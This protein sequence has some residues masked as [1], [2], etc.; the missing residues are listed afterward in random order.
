MSEEADV[1]DTGSLT[2]ESAVGNQPSLGS[3]ACISVASNDNAATGD[4]ISDL[5]PN[6]AASVPSNDEERL[7]SATSA[8]SSAVVPTSAPIPTPTVNSPYTAEAAQ[9]VEQEVERRAVGL[10]EPTANEQAINRDATIALGVPVSEHAPVDTPGLT[11]GSSTESVSAGFSGDHEQPVVGESIGVRDSVDYSLLGMQQRE[12]SNDDTTITMPAASSVDACYGAPE[13]SVAQ[14]TQPQTNE[15]WSVAQTPQWTVNPVADAPNEQPANTATFQTG[16]PTNVSPSAPV[17]VGSQVPIPGAS[18][19]VPYSVPGTQLFPAGNSWHVNSNLTNAHQ[20]AHHAEPQAYGTQIIYGQATLPPY[21]Q[22]V[23]VPQVGQNIGNCVHDEWSERMAATLRRAYAAI[24]GQPVN[25][26]MMDNAAPTQVEEP[27][28]MDLEEQQPQMVAEQAMGPEISPPSSSLAPAFVVTPELDTPM[29]S[30]VLTATE[31]VDA[32]MCSPVL[33]PTPEPASYFPYSPTM[34]HTPSV[35]QPA[36]VSA[37]PR[38]TV[39]SAMARRMLNR[40]RRRAQLG[41][42]VRP[43]KKVKAVKKKRSKATPTVAPQDTSHI[44]YY[45][46]IAWRTAL[47]SVFRVSFP[48]C[49][50]TEFEPQFKIPGVPDMWAPFP[51]ASAMPAGAEFGAANLQVPQAR[52][53]VVESPALEPGHN[54]PTAVDPSGGPVDELAQMFAGAMDKF[55]DTRYSEAA[56]IEVADFLAAHGLN[57]PPAT[58]TAKDTVDANAEDG[59]P[60]PEDV[61]GEDGHGGAKEAEHGEEGAGEGEGEAQIEVE[62]EGGDNAAAEAYLAKLGAELFG[63][64]GTGL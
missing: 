28:G 46:R 17:V 30:P 1:S 31:I 47:K 50:A 40:W 60:A 27:V 10:G 14:P 41:A 37:P 36:T 38:R 34:D 54:A 26:A 63:S 43:M 29:A 6:G 20:V 2:A 51:S 48:D 15:G 8:S 4:E 64:A 55:R 3:E 61:E 5:Q 58:E 23:E 42:E 16:L 57:Q 12:S 11:G 62:L 53:G 52:P 45:S 22:Q 25:I 24:Y 39:L 33:E 21:Q 56:E 13:P 19:E 49:E 35:P 44:S 59:L 18:L 7:L 32:P 9:V